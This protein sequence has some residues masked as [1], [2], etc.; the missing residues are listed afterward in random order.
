MKTWLITGVGKG[1]GRQLASQLL[2][3]GDRVVGTVR[4]QTDEEV[5][6]ALS[7]DRAVPLQIDVTRFE[8]ILG[9][10]AEIETRIGHIDI[11]VNNAGFGLTG[12]IEE[13]PIEAVKSLFDVN[14]LGTIAMIQAVLPG[15]RRRRAGHIINVSSVSGLAPWAGTGI[16]GASKYAVECLGQTLAEEVAPLGIHVTNVAPGGMRTDFSGGSLRA[17]EP[18]I[19]DYETTAHVAHGVLTDGMGQEPSSPEKIARAISQLVEMDVPP[20]LLLLGS[21]AYKYATYHLK[22]QLDGIEAFRDLTLSV[23]AETV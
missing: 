6:S 4:T 22:S 1:L 10:I 3:Q 5:F 8:E 20:R 13:T 18:S 9:K 11:L 7:A 16:Y 19:S 17:I 2:E 12:A 23:S 14:F 15:M 21:D